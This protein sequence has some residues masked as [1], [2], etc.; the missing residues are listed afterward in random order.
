MPRLVRA[1]LFLLTLAI[2]PL[3]CAF[4]QEADTKKAA[5]TCPPKQTTAEST[6][7]VSKTHCEILTS[8]VE[9]TLHFS[10]LSGATDLQDVVN[11]MR[12]LADIQRIQQ[13]LGDGIIIAVG[14]PEQ[15]AMAER[16]AAQIDHDK[17]PFG[18]RGYRIDVRIQEWEGDKKLGARLYS[19]VTEARRTAKMSVVKP[20]PPQVQ[21]E[22]AVESKQP[23][24]PRTVLSIE[25]QILIENERTL[26]LELETAF[27]SDRRESSG[28]NS[29][30]FRNRVVDTVELDKPTVVGRV[31]DPDGDHSFTVD[32]TAARVKD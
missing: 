16:L 25:C 1:V 18:G 30:L 11:A 12:S 32:V 4:S 5:E 9:K 2:F 28:G 24:E 20:A 27:A 26:E 31:D 14:T 8:C 22:I 3:Q 7:K 23:P 13:I 17:R 29:P 15:V 19:L 6:A 21:S 10:N